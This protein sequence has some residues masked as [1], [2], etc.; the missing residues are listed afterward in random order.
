MSYRYFNESLCIAGALIYSLA[1][2]LG[3]YEMHACPKDALPNFITLMSSVGLWSAF[4]CA[5]G[6]EDGIDE[7]KT[8]KKE[9]VNLLIT[10]P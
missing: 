9:L 5:R 4:S 6:L 8:N 2:G 10:D 7:K 1:T 3:L